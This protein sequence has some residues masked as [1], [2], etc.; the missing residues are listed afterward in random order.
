MV[1]V[2]P[3]LRHN[4]R[5]EV[6]VCQRLGVDLLQLRLAD[7]NRLR[8]RRDRDGGEDRANLRNLGQ[9]LCCNSRARTGK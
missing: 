7:L 4:R 1:E 3:E 9:V 2:E 8:Q 5:Q 6:P